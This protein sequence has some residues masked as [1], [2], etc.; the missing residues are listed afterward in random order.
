MDNTRR[1][2]TIQEKRIAKALGGKTQPGSGSLNFASLKGD[3]VANVE[4]ENWK[5]LVDGKTS[6][7]KTHQ[8]SNR[9]R[10]L[11]K[12]ELLKV[13]SQASEG[14]YD[15]GV[16]AVSFDN[17]KDYYVVEDVDFEN[18]LKAVTDYEQDI[19]RLQSIINEYNK[20]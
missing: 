15:M 18:L 17:I 9:T 7:K 20:G 5:V 3:V 12:D 13:K 16:L 1:H 8:P 4:S 10:T 6:M 14:G 2:S 11:K 19:V